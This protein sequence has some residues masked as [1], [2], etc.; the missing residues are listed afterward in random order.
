MIFTWN[1]NRPTL[2]STPPSVQI[3]K[4]F[5]NDSQLPVGRIEPYGGLLADRFGSE[6]FL[7]KDSLIEE[8]IFS[9]RRAAE[10]HRQVRRHCQNTIQPG[11]KMVDIVKNIE[12][13]L[14]FIVEKE[15][16]ER[17]Q[18]FPTGCSLNNVAAHYSPNYGDETVLGVDDVC[19]IDFGVHV[20]GYL[21]DSAFTVAFNPIYEPL[22]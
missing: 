20:K 1:W 13:T 21:I 17:G 6:E 11:Q 8:K 3:F 5:P 18:A 10:V 7:A 14:A 22:L 12:T 15:G 16:L 19:K 4:Q 2:Q 9:L